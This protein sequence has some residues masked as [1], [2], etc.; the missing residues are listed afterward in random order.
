MNEIECYEKQAQDFLEA[1]GTTIAKEFVKCDKYFPDDAEPRN[2]W[3]IT[4]KNQY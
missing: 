3:N 2:I 1:T 4:L